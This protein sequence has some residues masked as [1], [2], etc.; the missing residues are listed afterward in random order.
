MLAANDSKRQP[1]WPHWPLKV[2]R[3]STCDIALFGAATDEQGRCPTC[4]ER[5]ART[6]EC[7]GFLY[8]GETCTCAT[9]PDRCIDCMTPVHATESNDFG[10]CVACMVKRGIKPIFPSA[11][12]A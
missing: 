1:P 4:T 9:D 2:A 10:L 7:C 3:C 8:A 12:A 11:E 5:D 6:S